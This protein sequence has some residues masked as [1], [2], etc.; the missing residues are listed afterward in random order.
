MKV[1]IAAIGREKKSSPTSEIFSDYLKRLPWDVELREFEEKKSL[2][3]ALL[4]EK[5]AQMLLG[6][7]PSSAKVIALDEHG[8]NLSSEEFAAQ[9][10]KWQEH[11]SSHFVFMIGGAAGHGQAVKDRADMLLSLGKMT[12]PHMMVR[13]MLAEQLY[14]AHTILT[15]HPYHRA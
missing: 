15:G 14:R 3:P 1:T 2:P 12:W 7:A 6:A 10:A 5:E 9:L 8:K 11:G 13:S 4:M